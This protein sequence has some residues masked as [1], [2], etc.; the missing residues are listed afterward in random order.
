VV[1]SSA[2]YSGDAELKSD[3]MTAY[4]E[5]VRGSYVPA[6]K[7]AAGNCAF[8]LINSQVTLSF[9]TLEVEASISWC[10]AHSGTCD[11]ILLPVG[12]LLSESCGLVSVRRPLCRED[13]SEVFIAIIEW[14]ESRRTC[15][16]TFAISS[17]TPQRGRPGSRIYIPLEQGGPVIPPGTGF[18]LRRLLRLGGLLDALHNQNI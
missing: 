6:H 3:V 12:T 7:P 18:P 17:E 8:A 16:H 10:R 13:G 4:T 1:G 11:Q 9:D 5:I 2:S 15:N 14:S